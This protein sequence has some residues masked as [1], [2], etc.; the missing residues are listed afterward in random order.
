MSNITF[1]LHK[2]QYIKKLLEIAMSFVSRVLN[3]EL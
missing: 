3:F 2:G 1:P